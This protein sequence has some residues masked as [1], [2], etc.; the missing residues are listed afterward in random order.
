MFT[1]SYVC[2]GKL[3]VVGHR[4]RGRSAPAAQLDVDS[5]NAVAETLQAL[6]APSRLLILS[7]LRQA[8]A[9]LSGRWA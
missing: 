1:C 5:A 6:A 7:R 2:G 8:P 9:A 3:S 4:V